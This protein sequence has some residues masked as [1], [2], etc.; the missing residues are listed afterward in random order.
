MMLKPNQ[1]AQ[2]PT[3]IIKL[4]VGCILRH[5]A[6]KTPTL[7]MHSITQPKFIFPLHG[8]TMAPVI[9]Y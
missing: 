9:G 1:L 7:E 2:P 5:Y 4:N 6:L 8:P 3:D